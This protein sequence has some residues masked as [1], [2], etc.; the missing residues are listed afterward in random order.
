L[1]VKGISMPSCSNPWLTGSYRKG[2][3]RYAISDDEISRRSY[4]PLRTQGGP[5]RES[6]AQGGLMNKRLGTLVSALVL[7]ASAQVGSA[8]HPSPQPGPCRITGQNCAPRPCQNLPG[9]RCVIWPRL[10]RR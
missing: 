1:W 6:G 2:P 3:N 8:A 9:T 4:P 10:P 5:R 7:A